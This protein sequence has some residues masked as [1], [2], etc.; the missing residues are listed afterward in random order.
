M[1]QLR[2]IVKSILIFISDALAKLQGFHFPSKFTW[3]WKLEMLLGLYEK[4]TTR[5]FKKRIERGMIVADI[6]A[7]IGYFTR[8]FSKLA[9]SEGRV[10]SFEAD[11]E[12]FALLKKNTSGLPNVT[13]VNKA[14]AAHDGA[15]DFFHLKE[16]TGCHSTI[17]EE[18]AE[19][20]RV[21]AATLDTALKELGIERIDAIKMDIEGGE[22]AALEGMKNILKSS[23][24]LILVTE[25]NSDTLSRAGG[26]K[27]FLESLE[28]AGFRL[29]SIEKSGA[30]PLDK[31]GADGNIF[32]LFQ[33]S[34]PY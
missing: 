13:L 8:L 24:R 32:A 30:L 6:G 4:E 12:N 1:T 34:S 33:K 2:G 11:P 26:R 23:G 31:N 7:H 18:G 29:F 25:I 21:P 27:S 3:K 17:P 16:S 22:P 15:I 28:K 5:F 10:I 14:V 9:G 19:R 20:I